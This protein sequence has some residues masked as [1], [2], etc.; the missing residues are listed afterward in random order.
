MG[1]AHKTIE[2]AEAFAKSAEVWLAIIAAGLTCAILFPDA[3][4]IAIT[5]GLPA[6]IFTGIIFGVVTHL[7]WKYAPAAEKLLGKL[8]CPSL[9]FRF[10]FVSFIALPVV[11]V[12]LLSL[13]DILVVLSFVRL[14]FGT[15]VAVAGYFIFPRLLSNLF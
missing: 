1:K 15:V 10:L 7:V 11:A 4:A 5:G 14:A 13:T 6:Y 12:W 9:V 8:H 2:N 3:G